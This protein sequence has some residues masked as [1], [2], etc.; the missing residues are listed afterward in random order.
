VTQSQRLE[1]L[2]TFASLALR[3]L[4]ALVFLFAA[5]PKLA[6][7]RT[8]AEQVSYYD[9]LPQLS[10]L[11]AVAIPALE[12]L[13]A[14]ALLVAPRPWRRA[15]LLMVFALLCM[16]TYA[17]AQAYLRGINTECGCFGSGGERIGIPKLVENAGLI[18]AV[19]VAFL[20]EVRQSET[21]P[22]E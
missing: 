8:F 18:A 2:S 12:L 19:V 10:A 14:V 16:F 17:V 4:L 9:L 13:A 22:R 6:D 3:V 20:L 15:A 5:Y 21:A 11:V 1:Q 7:T